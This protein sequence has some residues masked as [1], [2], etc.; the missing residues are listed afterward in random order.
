[1]AEQK[2]SELPGA[3][4]LT[5]TEQVIVNQNAITKLTDVD[6][7]K[8]YVLDNGVSGTFTNPTSITVVNGIITAIS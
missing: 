6:K 8:D 3:S 4:T 1:M 7:V 2:I 5:G